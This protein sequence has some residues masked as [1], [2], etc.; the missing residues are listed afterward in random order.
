MH[1]SLARYVP[2][3]QNHPHKIILI[4]RKY[5]RLSLTCDDILQIAWKDT[6]ENAAYYHA[7]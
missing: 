5:N 7:K 6:F 3:L 2:H 4:I 1:N